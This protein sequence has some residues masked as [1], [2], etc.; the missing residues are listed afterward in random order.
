MAANLSAQNKPAYQLFNQKGKPVNWGKMMK[1][2]NKADVVFFGEFHNNPICHWLQLEMTMELAKG[3]RS[4]ILGAEMFETDNQEALNAYLSGEIDQ[5]GLDTLARLWSNFKTDY[6]PIVDFAKEKQ[7]PFIAT[8]VPR[9]YASMV[10]RNDFEALEILPQEE[11]N[12]IA[13]LPI[14]YDPELPGYKAMLNM[15]SDHASPTFPKAQAIKDATMAHF[16]S[17]NYE[18]G[19]VFLHLNGTYHTDNFEGILWYMKRMKPDLKYITISTV[20]QSDLKKLND[21]NK[22]KADFILVVSETMTTTY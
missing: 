10:F 7:I 12:W 16:T 17:V 1:E 14:D 22:G 11:K 13:P 15:M 21:D 18:D 20:Q 8:N 4:L 9:R 2:I 19:S 3:P 5:K 6:K